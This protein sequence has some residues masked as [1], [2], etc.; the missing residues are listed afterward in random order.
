MTR[1]KQLGHSTATGCG[2]A[3]SRATRTVV[4]IIFPPGYAAAPAPGGGTGAATFSRGAQRPG[5]AAAGFSGRAGALVSFTGTSS[6]RVAAPVAT[7][8]RAH[9]TAFLSESST[10]TSW[11]GAHE[12]IIPPGP[13]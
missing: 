9:A 7:N 6:T 13:Y 4:S 1:A 11:S 8:I 5:A 12:S 2:G 10:S 3:S